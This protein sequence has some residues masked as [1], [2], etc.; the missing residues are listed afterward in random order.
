MLAHVRRRVEEIGSVFKL[1]GARVVAILELRVD[2]EHKTVFA[3]T[4]VNVAKRAAVLGSNSG[5]V[6][7]ARFVECLS[8]A[9]ARN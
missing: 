2:R 5:A 8:V 9:P 1:K 3:R 4:F 6:G 7:P